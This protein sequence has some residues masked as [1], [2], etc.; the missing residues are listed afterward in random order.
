MLKVREIVLKTIDSLKDCLK[1]PPPLIGIEKVD[2]DGYTVIINAW[3]N[4]HGFQD[5]KLLLM[6]N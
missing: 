1:D 6:R 2:A 3:A 4:S 5:I